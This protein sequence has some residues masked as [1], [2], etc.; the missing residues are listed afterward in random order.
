ML[1]FTAKQSN[2]WGQL[3]L[4]RYHYNINKNVINIKHKQNV[5]LKLYLN[6]FFTKIESFKK[7]KHYLTI[8]LEI[9]KKT[10]FLF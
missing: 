6:I 4:F 10:Y 1:I 2:E 3:A 9:K 7:Y 5:S 8:K